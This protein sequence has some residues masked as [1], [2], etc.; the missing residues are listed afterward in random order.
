MTP[1]QQQEII[2]LRVQK[3]TPK[4]IARKL[5][6]KVAEVSAAIKEQAEQTTLTRVATGELNPVVE[7]LVNASCAEKFLGNS[8]TQESESDDDMNGGLTIVSVT[9]QVGYNRLNV[10]TYMLDLWCLGVKDT[11]G[12]RQLNRMKYL[13]FIEA[14]YHGFA[15]E[16]QKITLEQAQTLVFSAV[17][18]AGQ[19]G[20]KAHP[21][22]EKSRSH[23]GEWSGEPKIQ[24]GRNGKA[25][26]V[27]G[28]YDNPDKILKTLR[29]NVGEGNFDYSLGIG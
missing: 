19:L 23:L 25:F 26:Y 12:P 17:D 14:V 16:T 8:A 15:E 9:R 27:S 1:E 21:N 4:Q 18:Y 11:I 2:N 28:P 24:C 13:Q 22:F 10:C 20:F 29:E 7:C 5:G 6:L 3:L